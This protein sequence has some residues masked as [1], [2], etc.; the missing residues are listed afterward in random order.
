FLSKAEAQITN[1]GHALRHIVTQAA[2]V[3]VGQFLQQRRVSYLNLQGPAARRPDSGLSS[4]GFA[5]DL[6]PD[7]LQPEPLLPAAPASGREQPA[8][9]IF[10]QFRSAIVVHSLAC[11]S[12]PP[13]A[14]YV[15]GITRY[16]YSV[17]TL[18]RAGTLPS[19]SSATKAVSGCS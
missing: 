16:E 14:A 13:N 1:G 19:T 12:V 11:G 5:G 18:K 15:S 4:Q 17:P 8:Q 7:L 6:S 9:D 3:E 2:L 10:Q